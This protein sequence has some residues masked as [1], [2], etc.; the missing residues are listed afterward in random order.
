MRAEKSER[1][2]R[3]GGVKENRGGT[4]SIGCRGGRKI[5]EYTTKGDREDGGARKNMGGNLKRERG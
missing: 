1:T 5:S 2:E 3:A 4:G